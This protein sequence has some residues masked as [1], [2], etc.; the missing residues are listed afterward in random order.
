MAVGGAVSGLLLL[1][2]AAAPSRRST[3]LLSHRRVHTELLKRPVDRPQNEVRR[4][5]VQ[6]EY[7]AGCCEKGRPPP[8]F[9]GGLR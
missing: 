8:R 9:R 5:Y 6:F 3:G 7:Q 4:V 2:Y 1:R